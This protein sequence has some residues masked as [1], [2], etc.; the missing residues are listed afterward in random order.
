VYKLASFEEIV[1]SE[2]ICH[3]LH[4]MK[5]SVRKHVG[6]KLVSPRAATKKVMAFI[7]QNWHE[8]PRSVMFSSALTL[9]PGGSCSRGD[10]VLCEHR[11][12]G[13]VWLH[14]EVDGVT[15]T[16]LL[17]LD[18]VSYDDTT[19]KAVWRKRADPVLVQSKCILCPLPFSVVSSD[20]I[21]TLLPLL[22]RF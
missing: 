19:F 1:L 9:L 6:H 17:P 15:V 21:A 10:I 11:T 4:L 18:N 7:N 13:E 20:L 2:M 5:T 8:E 16:L 3:D 14:A 12:A 22:H